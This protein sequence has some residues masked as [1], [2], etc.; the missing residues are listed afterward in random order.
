L[1]MKDIKIWYIGSSR[2]YCKVPYE[3]SRVMGKN[4]PIATYEKDGRVKHLQY[5]I[6]KREAEL[7]MT[8]GTL[9]PRKSKNKKLF[10]QKAV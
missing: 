2:Y 6:N 8:F 5:E 3:K 10:Q 1:I 7:L 9:I 4:E